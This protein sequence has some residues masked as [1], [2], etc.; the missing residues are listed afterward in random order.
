VA[1]GWGVLILAMVSYLVA[2][3]RGVRPWAEVAKHLGVASLVIAAS[4]LIGAWIV[5]HVQ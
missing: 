5:R 3:T 2:G 4:R 1:L